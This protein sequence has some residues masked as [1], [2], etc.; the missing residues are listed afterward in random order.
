MA[1]FSGGAVFFSVVQR[2]PFDLLVFP[3]WSTFSRGLKRL[4]FYFQVLWASEFWSVPVAFLD[5]KGFR[6][7]A[8]ETNPDGDDFIVGKKM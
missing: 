5:L 4:T 3:F 1:P 6:G 7:Q 8:V 2:R